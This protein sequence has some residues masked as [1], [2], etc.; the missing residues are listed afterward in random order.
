M[1]DILRSLEGLPEFNAH[2][3]KKTRHLFMFLE[4]FLLRLALT[5]T[6]KGS[7]E[8]HSAEAA[9]KLTENLCVK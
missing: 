4:L 5:R 1:N 8:K 3:Q 2:T 6:E 7:E 9:T